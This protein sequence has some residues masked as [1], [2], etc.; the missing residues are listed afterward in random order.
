MKPINRMCD[1]TPRW[2]QQLFFCGAKVYVA[3]C[4]LV[5]ELNALMYYDRGDTE[6]FV[7]QGE[8]DFSRKC[9]FSSTNG[10]RQYTTKGWHRNVCRS[11]LCGVHQAS[12]GVH[13]YNVKHGAYSVICR[14]CPFGSDCQC[15]TVS[16]PICDHGNSAM[17]LVIY[18]VRV[19]SLKW[20]I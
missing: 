5:K 20:L 16:V 8:T 10:T 6:T 18:K 15:C 13:L 19:S 2:G 11:R 12:R 9:L 4:V 3:I 14:C 1:V 17:C 7:E